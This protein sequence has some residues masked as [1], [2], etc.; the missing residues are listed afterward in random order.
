VVRHQINDQAASVLSLI[1]V[2]IKCYYTVFRKNTSL[3]F[4]LYQRGKCLGD[5]P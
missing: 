4:L 2:A 5:A 1:P 3:R